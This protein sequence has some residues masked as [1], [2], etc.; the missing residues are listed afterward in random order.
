MTY[1]TLQVKHQDIALLITLNRPSKRNAMSLEMVEELSACLDDAAANNAIRAIVIQGAGGHF[2]AGGDIADMAQAR[3]Q[4]AAGDA[5]AYRDFNRRFGHLLEQVNAQP[6]VVMV[7]LEGAV[8]G[9]GLGLACVSDIAIASSD[10]QLGLPE[11]GLGIIPAQIAPFVVQRIGLT[12]TRKL[13]LSGARFDAATAHALGLIHEIVPSDQLTTCCSTYL[14]QVRRCAPAANRATKQLLL[15]VGT[16][17]Q[18]RL[19]DDA[20]NAFSTAVS[21]A[22]GMEGTMAFLQKRKPNWAQ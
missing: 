19:L 13:A 20:A 14:A 22:E 7:L 10:C 6:Q 15:E 21:G 17:P 11:T 9:G 12:Q 2:C 16:K 8:L 1:N 4:T 5:H 3:Q 18:A